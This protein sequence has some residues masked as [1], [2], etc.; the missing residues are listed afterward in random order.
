M[1]L[2]DVKFAVNLNFNKLRVKITGVDVEIFQY[3]ENIKMG[4]VLEI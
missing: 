3:L 1:K 2:K 4:L